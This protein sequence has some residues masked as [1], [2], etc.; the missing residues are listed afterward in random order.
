MAKGQISGLLL[1][2]QNFIPA[3][4]FGF[5]AGMTRHRFDDVWRCMAFSEQN[6]DLGAT[7]SVQHLWELVNDFVKSINVHRETFFNPSELICVDESIS[8]WYGLGGHWIDVGLPEYVA[9]DRKP[10]KG[11]EIQNS[12][13][14]RSGIM[15]RLQLVTTSDEEVSRTTATESIFLHETNVLKRLV[16]P[17]AVTVRILCAVSNTNAYQ[18]KSQ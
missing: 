10:E 18:S 15:M 14:G 4:A 17:W 1:I 13:C 16:L 2:S 6:S 12:A 9:I 8:R 3:P 7:T 5:R 11:C